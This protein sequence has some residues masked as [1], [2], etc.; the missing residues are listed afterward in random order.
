MSKYDFDWS[1]ALTIH[2]QRYS[3]VFHALMHKEEF[4]NNMRSVFQIFDRYN[5]FENYKKQWIEKNE[6][7]ISVDD[8]FSFHGHY[9]FP[10]NSIIRN[11]IT[12]DENVWHNVF[13]FSSDQKVQYSLVFSNINKTTFNVVRQ[14]YTNELRRICDR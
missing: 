3:N 1:I 6:D 11:K 2:D 7:G 4:K 12:F 5:V 10:K 8:L 13:E 14:H 9:A